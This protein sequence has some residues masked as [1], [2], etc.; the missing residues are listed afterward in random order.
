MVQA[1]ARRPDNWGAT[2]T[3]DIEEDENLMNQLR[4]LGYIE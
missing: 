3:I 2:Q 4:S 1:L